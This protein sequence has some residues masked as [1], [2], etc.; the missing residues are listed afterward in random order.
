MAHFG[1]L[2]VQQNKA[3]REDLFW[4][5]SGKSEYTHSSGKVVIRKNNNDRRW[6]A[7][8]PEGK[9]FSHSYL[10]VDGKVLNYPISEHSLTCAK[11]EVERRIFQ[12]E[13]L[14]N[15]FLTAI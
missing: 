2:T 11:L 9:T 13:S 4:F 12:G 6:Y 3:H 10:R 8:T 15:G 14:S 5:K 7:H 1:H